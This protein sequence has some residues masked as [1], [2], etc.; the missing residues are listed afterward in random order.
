MRDPGF[1][2]VQDEQRYAP[3]V[4]AVNEL[5]DRLRDRDGRGWMPHVA[6]HYGGI[7]AQVLLLM[8][9]PGPMTD[10]QVGAKGSGFL[11]VENDDAT[12]ERAATLLD[13]ANLSPS[14]C[15]S[16]NAYPWYIN[17]APTSRQLDDG[18]PPL[19][20]L[21]ELLPRLKVVIPR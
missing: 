3:H 5:V 9:D 16:W 1:R 18:I 14:D 20:D 6:P 17:R 12:A 2:A 11:C 7:D 13:E 4:Q 8:R 21:L 10:S 19:V 15:I